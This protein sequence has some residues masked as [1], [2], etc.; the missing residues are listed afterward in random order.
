MYMR[1]KAIQSENRYNKIIH[2]M[3]KLTSLSKSNHHAAHRLRNQ[4]SQK[5]LFYSSKDIMMEQTHLWRN[6]G[7]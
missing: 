3:R 2:E 1:E 6:K 5:A 4:I 7:I